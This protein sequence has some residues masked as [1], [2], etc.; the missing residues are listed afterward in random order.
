MTDVDYGELS[1]EELRA[2]QAW[3]ADYFEQAGRG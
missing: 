1:L 2:H 3:M